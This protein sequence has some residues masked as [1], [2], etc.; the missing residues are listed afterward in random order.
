M[1]KLAV[2]TYPNPAQDYI[3][4]IT[5]HQIT[6]IRIMNIAGQLLYKGIEKR[7][8]VSDLPQGIYYLQT[9]T[10][11]GISNIKFIKR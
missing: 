10:P 1:N 8:N 2:L 4:V 9:I 5:N 3:N 7:I 11:E 6:E